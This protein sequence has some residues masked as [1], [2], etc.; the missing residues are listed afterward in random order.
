MFGAIASIAAPVVGKLLDKGIDK[1]FGDDDKKQQNNPQSAQLA[2][3]LSNSSGN[4]IG[5]S[6][7]G[8]LA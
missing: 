3:L 4:V 2:Q 7:G 6:L 8:L 1:L 5:D